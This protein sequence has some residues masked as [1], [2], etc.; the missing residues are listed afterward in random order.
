MTDESYSANESR[1]QK[2]IRAIS[3]ASR[4]GELKRY[5]IAIN[6]YHTFY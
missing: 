4:Q 1:D 5:G 6:D 2:K 3:K